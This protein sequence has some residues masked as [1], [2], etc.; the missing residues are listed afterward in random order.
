MASIIMAY[1]A[2]PT[3]SGSS[4]SAYIVMADIVLAYRVR[5]L[6]VGLCIVMAYIVMAY[7]AEMPRLFSR[8]KPLPFD[9]ARTSCRFV[10]VSVST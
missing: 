7:V 2:W 3:E 8:S 5:C 6:G 10:P 1:M 4:A 9:N